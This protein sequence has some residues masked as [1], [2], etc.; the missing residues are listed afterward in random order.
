MHGTHSTKST[1]QCGYEVVRFDQLPAVA[2]P[3]GTSQR[4]FANLADFP[5]TIHRVEIAADAR[6]H[7][8]R[9][10]TEVYYFLA[11]EP[12]A[13]MEL[14]DERLDVQAGM[15]LL[16]RPLTRHRAVG[17][18]TVLNIVLPKFDPADEWFD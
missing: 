8:H 7:Y 14:D 3:C 4:A 11:C 12:G 15:C 1:G 5:A 9:Q 17:K 6:R 10:L 16:I 13:Q 2:C 18:M